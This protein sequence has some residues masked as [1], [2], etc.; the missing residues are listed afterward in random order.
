MLRAFMLTAIFCAAVANAVSAA[1]PVVIVLQSPTGE[2]LPAPPS[3]VVNGQ[4][5]VPGTLGDAYSAPSRDQRRADWRYRAAEHICAPDGCPTAVG[6]SNAWTEF[7]FVFGSCRQFF[8][9]A[10][11]TEGCCNKT[12]VPPPARSYFRHFND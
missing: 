12:T 5:Y 2:P 4:T 7:K 1:E 10:D 3:V 8:G 6:C 11:S 9:T